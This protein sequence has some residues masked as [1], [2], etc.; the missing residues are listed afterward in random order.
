MPPLFRVD[1]TG[2]AK[3]QMR[4]LLVKASPGNERQVVRDAL[5][6][7]VSQ[8]ETRPQDWGDP[9]HRT[10]KEGGRV[11][12]GIISPLVV[13]YALFESEKVVWLLDVRALPKSPLAE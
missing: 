6:S 7:I 13:R 8:L 1:P 4:E 2:P 3:Q 12:R 10:H 11:Y 5:R 9:L